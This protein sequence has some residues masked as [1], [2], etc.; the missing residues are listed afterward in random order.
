VEDTPE[1]I[2]RKQ[3]EIWLAKPEEERLRLTLQMNDEL[4][5]FWTEAK[6]NMPPNDHPIIPAN[7]NIDKGN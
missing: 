2:K 3:L 6:K 4:N 1:H 7:Q 5:A